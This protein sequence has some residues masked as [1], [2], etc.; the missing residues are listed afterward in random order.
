M[1]NRDLRDLLLAAKYE[2]LDSLHAFI[3]LHWSIVEPR[4]P[5]VDGWHIQAICEH[6]EAVSKGQI[7]NLIISVP[8]RHMKSTAVNVMWPAWSWL[9]KPASRWI[10]GSYAQNLSIRDS[11]KCRRVIESHLYRQTFN[12]KW[13]LSDDQN[14]KT[15]FSNTMTGYRIAT[16]V[17]GTGTGEGGDFIVVDDPIKATDAESEVIRQNVI[18]WWDN[19]MSTRGNNP[20]TAARVIIMQRLHQN[21]L[22]G[23]CAKQGGYEVLKLPAEF[24][25]TKK[26]VTCIG[27]EDPRKE[28]GELL[29]P[30]R[31]T[32]DF[33]DK[34]KVQLGSRGSAA[35]LQQDPKAS[36]D[37]LFK[38]KWWKTYKEL[39]AKGQWKRVVQF[40][41][42]ASKP[43]ISN[44]Y[45]ICA[46]WIETASGFYLGDL[47]REKLEYPQLK[48][49]IKMQFAKWNP[50][51][52]QIEDKS[53]G[54][55]LIQDLRQETTL[56]IL[57]YNPGQN[58]KQVRAAAATPTVE[59][60]NCYLP[61]VAPWVEDFIR[62]HEQFPDGDHDDQ[63]DT[64]SQM[65]E[66][67]NRQRAYQPRVRSL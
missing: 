49:A 12:P 28:K 50:V 36:E 62:E 38:R 27:W 21:D 66:Y 18:D 58:D 55:S 3:R 35:Q 8:P 33:I 48:T 54:I 29:W 40:W 4:E 30:E 67:F 47:L 24:E 41:D 23:H 39:P 6:L 65:V 51:A 61:E 13:I 32:K 45:S 57:A 34:L 22:A 42:T 25:P 2:A 10:F 60:G 52:V 16:S 56:P 37:G 1:N 17:G 19:E 5:F 15:R 20:A 53:S 64:T 63:V 59:A 44:D 46:T 43:G 7:R 31:F 14:Q 26:S 11:I 9:R